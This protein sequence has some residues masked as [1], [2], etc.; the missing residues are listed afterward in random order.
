[1][2]LDFM[3]LDKVKLLV[4][5]FDHSYSLWNR[6]AEDFKGWIHKNTQRVA[7]IPVSPSAEGYALL[8]FYVVDRILENTIFQNGEGEIEL[9]S[10]KVHE[11]S[12]G[13]A[14][15]FRED[16]SL[17]QFTLNEIH[18]SQAIIDEWPFDWWESLKT[19]Q[20]FINP[21]VEQNL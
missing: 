19:G 3:L 16:L 14:E 13:Y 6:E 2:V 4:D 12:T 18:F 21:E 7:E 9:F 11:T 20:K 1:M 5:S 10:V 8:F 15:A 17:V